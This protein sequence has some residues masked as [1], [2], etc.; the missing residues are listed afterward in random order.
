MTLSTYL[1]FDG[2]CRE[3]F[4]FY[5]S[6]FGGDFEVIQTFGDGPDEMPVPGDER[7]RV[8]HVSYPIGSSVLMGSDSLSSSPEAT[9]I[10]NNFSISL[11]LDEPRGDRRTLREDVRGRRGGG[12]AARGDVLGRVLRRLHGQV[13]HQLAVQL[14]AAA[15][16]L[17]LSCPPARRRAR[18]RARYPGPMIRCISS[19]V[20]A[21]SVSLETLPDSAML[22]RP[23]II[24]SSLG[25]STTVTRS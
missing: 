14:R 10:G 6:V 2:N 9:Q 23:F 4:E 8:M 5:R 25:A 18:P 20:K 12:D 11:P 7:D 24:A 21:R 19:S 1:T 3:V 16:R 15:A 13:R 22:N 17:G